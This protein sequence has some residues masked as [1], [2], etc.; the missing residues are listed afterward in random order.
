MLKEYW[1]LIKSVNYM[2][3]VNSGGGVRRVHVRM[4]DR[5]AAHLNAA[6]LRDSHAPERHAP[7]QKENGFRD[8]DPN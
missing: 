8:D 7:D 1:P 5:Q 6:T 4:T 3:R 2:A